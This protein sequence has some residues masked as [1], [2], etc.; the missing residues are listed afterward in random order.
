M[1]GY[2]PGCLGCWL[3]HSESLTKQ[4]L[5]RCSEGLIYSD[6][7]KSMIQ[8]NRNKQPVTMTPAPADASRNSETRT[9]G[10]WDV[11]QE[12]TEL[13]VVIGSLHAFQA[14]ERDRRARGPIGAGRLPRRARRPPQMPALPPA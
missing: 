5:A 6:V 11:I 14:T 4:N 7:A 13:A 8:M 10:A 3:A 1:V 12:D 9:I 2:V